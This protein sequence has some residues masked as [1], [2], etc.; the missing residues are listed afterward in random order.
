M[1][2]DET[3]ERK[4]K[5]RAR[6]K[7]YRERNKV[8]V[9]ARQKEY[10]KA[11]KEKRTTQKGSKGNL[12]EQARRRRERRVALGLTTKGKPR[13][14]RGRGPSVLTEEKVIMVRQMFAA[15]RSYRQCATVAGAGYSAVRAAIRN[16]T[17]KHV[18][19]KI[20]RRLRMSV[21]PVVSAFGSPLTLEDVAEIKAL[22]Q[23][24]IPI[25]QVAQ[26][27]SRSFWTIREIKRGRRWRD[28]HPAP[29]LPLVF[30][31]PPKDDT[32]IRLGQKRLRRAFR[33]R[34]GR[35]LQKRDIQQATGRDAR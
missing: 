21:A 28:V 22:L 23:A 26:R 25:L 31:R 15:G 7:E 1:S 30:T 9:A 14:I 35:N 11:N 5:E 18:G 33:K 16:E 29:E 3:D 4:A 8:K 20:D 32:G 34:F 6:G 19:E 27:Y 2:T 24:G 17:W 13:S 12:R 10:R